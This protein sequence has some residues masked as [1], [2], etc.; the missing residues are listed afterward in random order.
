VHEAAR[1]FGP[2]AEIVAR[3]VEK[4]F[5]YLEAPVRRVSGFDTIVPLFAYEQAY[6]PSPQ[7]IVHAARETLNA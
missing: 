3:L 7:R 6:L 1:S 2:A 5:W 4:A